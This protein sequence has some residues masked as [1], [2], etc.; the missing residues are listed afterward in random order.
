MKKI[1]TLLLF[2][3]IQFS[4]SKAQ[5]DTL[6]YENFD[7][8][9][10]A[11]YLPFSSGT[12]QQWVDLDYDQ[13]TDANG[14]PGNWFWSSASFGTPDSTGCLF[15]S[16][17]FNPAGQCVNYLMTPP[18]QIV[19]A[20]AVLNWKSAPRQTPYYLDGYKILVSTGF[21]YETSF[22]DTIFVAGEYLSGASSNGADY[23]LYSFSPGFI[24]GEDGTYVEFDPTSDSSRLVGDLR[25]FNVS[26]AQYSGQTIYIAF[27]HDSY[28]DNLIA[29]DDILVTG[30]QPLGI[31]EIKNEA[32]LS[33][34]PNPASDKIEI[35]YYLPATSEIIA[36]VYDMK[37]A[38]VKE[39]Q[40]DMQIKGNQKIILDVSD[41]SAG[42]Y[43]L[44]IIAG[45][46]VI[47]SDFVVSK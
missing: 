9:P 31:S 34:S 41:I 42:N 10:T 44:S 1:F 24:H 39:M 2:I 30:T 37:G 18:I 17:W 26:L 11:N 45:K 35:N 36:R 12:D 20:N 22:T 47:H 6:L 3:F 43:N 4:I 32:G 14:R 5:N 19:D 27:L 28:D 25:P 13:L 40:Q 46:K 38:L 16:S 15:S 33:I 7:V 23:S 21:N 8:D 29:V